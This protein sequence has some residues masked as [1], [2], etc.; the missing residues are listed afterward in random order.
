MTGSVISA[1]TPIVLVVDD[2]RSVRDSLRRLI[3]SVGMTVEVFPTRSSVP[4][5]SP[6][7][8]PWLPRPRRTPPGAQRPR[9]SARACQDRRN[10]AN[11]LSNGSR[12][13]PDVGSGHE[14]RCDRVSDK[15][16]SRTGPSRRH[17]I[18]DRS[19]SHRSSGA[20]RAGR[21]SSPVRHP[22]A[23]RTGRDGR[24]GRRPTQQAHVR[25]VRDYRSATVKEQ[26]GQVM[27]KMRAGSLAA[28]VRP[29]ARVGT[30][31]A[32]SGP[33]PPRSGRRFPPRK[34]DW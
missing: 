3:A 22:D 2:D 16:V 12:R 29:A 1:E 9:P 26:R 18:R 13:H 17:S 11:H 6:A 32:R 15:A 34:L 4:Q 31:P 5:Y 28:L 10:A 21:A 20:A 19:R 27:Q 23:A 25:R 14:S 8:C 30:T 7:G 24:G 33:T